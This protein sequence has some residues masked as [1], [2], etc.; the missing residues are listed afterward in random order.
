MTKELPVQ[1]LRFSLPIPPSG[2]DAGFPPT[3]TFLGTE[4]KFYRY[5]RWPGHTINDVDRAQNIGYYLGRWGGEPV[6]TSMLL[7]TGRRVSAH[8]IP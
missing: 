5:K 6:Q 4:F 1:M 7:D 2:H 8:I 3:V